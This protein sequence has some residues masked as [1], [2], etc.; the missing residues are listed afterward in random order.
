MNSGESFKEFIEDQLSAL[1]GIEF[2]RMF[3]AYGIYWGEKFFA[4]LDEGR[5][6]FKTNAESRVRYQSLGSKPFTYEKKDPKTK[7]K[8]TACLK[9]YYEV[10]PDILE[11]ARLLREWAV[12]SS[13]V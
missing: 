1:D 13:A 2:K 10:P 7:Q 3:G 6:Y 5:L 8:K 4:I 9:N 12:E 11:N